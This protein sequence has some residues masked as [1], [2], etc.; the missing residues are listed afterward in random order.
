MSLL[1]SSLRSNAFII[2]MGLLAHS[3]HC[4]VKA[5]PG[6]LEAFRLKS[7]NTWSQRDVLASTIL[8]NQQTK[9]LVNMSVQ[10]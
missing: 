7:I 9:K 1:S 6:E 4:F 10:R 2:S 5:F 3:R 8:S